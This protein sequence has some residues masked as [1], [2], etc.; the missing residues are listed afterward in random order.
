LIVVSLCRSVHY[1]SETEH[2]QSSSGNMN[3]ITGS[4]VIARPRDRFQ[5][6]LAHPLWPA[7]GGRVDPLVGPQCG[8]SNDAV[9]VEQQVA[10]VN[11]SG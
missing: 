6:Y 11:A 10:R 1:G 8:I 7:P 2:L 9:E 4:L 5:R 3:V